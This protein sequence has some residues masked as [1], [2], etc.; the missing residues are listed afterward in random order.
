MSIRRLSD[1]TFLACLVLATAD[2][3]AA[4]PAP[5]ST[6][7]P[8]D[9]LAEYRGRFKL[10]MDRYRAGALAEAI[11][12]WEP[13]YRELGGREGYRLAYNLGVAYAELGDATHAAE[14][15]QAF[16]DELE[17][18]RAR[19]EKVSAVVTKEEADARSR[20]AGLLATKGRIRVDPGT[21]ALAAQVD[22]NE[23]RAVAYVAW[24]SPGE[25][26]VHFAPGT[27]STETKSVTVNA[28]EIID[29][30]PS[31][32]RASPVTTPTPTPTQTATPTPTATAT[33]TPTATA[34]ATATA[35]PTATPTA[36]RIQRRVVY[37][38]AHPF[39]PTLLYVSG[40]LAVATAVAAILL[41]NHA[42]TLHDRFVSEND[43]NGLIPQGDR[44]TFNT[45]RTEAYAVVGTACGLGLLTAGLGAWYVLGTSRREVALTPTLGLTRGGASVGVGA[46]F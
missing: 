22:A 44:G 33:A 43:A 8:E 11:G 20:I 15:L 27:P 19:A 12:Y 16:L 38:T 17:S 29:V 41:E 3:R 13:V 14:R 1:L 24:V 23:P 35:T 4:P 21:P 9:P 37:E 18:R 40:G 45:A 10:G 30:A 7:A 26:A 46:A 39:S 28:G 6:G 42:S 36:T 5:S 32:P 31:P 2:A 34:T 25:H